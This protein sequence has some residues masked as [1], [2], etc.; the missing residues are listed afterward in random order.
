MILLLSLHNMSSKY[1]MANVEMPIEITPDN[2]AI[3]LHEYSVINIVS[4]IDSVNNLKKKNVPDIITQSTELFEK[5][6]LDNISSTN[7]DLPHSGLFIYP[8]EIKTKTSLQKRNTSFKNRKFRQ[9][10]TSK[11]R[12]PN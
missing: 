9:R 10:S 11:Y 5:Q 8:E 1:V 4:I 7:T 3:P 12:E 2:K 6:R